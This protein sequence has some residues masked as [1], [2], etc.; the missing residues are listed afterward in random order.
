MLSLLM[1][2]SALRGA[3]PEDDMRIEEET[4]EQRAQT[5]A[6]NCAAFGR[7]DEADLVDRLRADGAV[8]LSLVAVEAGEVVGHILFT[9]LPTQVDGRE[10]DA[11]ALAPMAVDP[12]RQ[13]DGVG[14]AL[15]REGLARLAQDRFEAVIVLGHP[16][17]YPR[18]G[19]SAALAA[20]L[21]SPFAGEA[22]MALELVAGALRGE[23]GRVRYPAAFGIEDED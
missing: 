3:G 15:V 10:V 18:F 6:L 1:F 20:K 7:A 4:R 13:N 21:A 9:E 12:R 23:A 16:A 5:H 2:G 14:S 17:Y 19:F 22:F 8:R 11:V